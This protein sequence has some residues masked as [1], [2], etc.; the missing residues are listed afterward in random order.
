LETT[1]NE[2]IPHDLSQNMDDGN[3]KEQSSK[4]CR[5]RAKEKTTEQRHQ[6]KKKQKQ[7]NNKQKNH[8]TTPKIKKKK[9]KKKTTRESGRKKANERGWVGSARTN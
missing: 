2:L 7:T 1:P 6:K 9:K 3:M 5:D 8:N 4:A